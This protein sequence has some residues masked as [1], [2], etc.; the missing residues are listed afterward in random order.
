VRFLLKAVLPK[1]VQSSLRWRRDRARLLWRLARNFAY[2]YRRYASWSADRSI[3][4]RT[5]LAALITMDYH[6][7]EKAL[8]LRDPH[9]AFGGWF[10]PRLLD[11]LQLYQARYGTDRTAQVATGALGAYQRFNSEHGV[12]TASIARLA[13]SVGPSNGSSTDAGAEGG[14][15]SVLSDELRGAS[16]IALER[17]SVRATAFEISLPKTS[18]WRR[19]RQP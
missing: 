3:K 19:S 9:P 13:V 12:A 16:V 5:N 7:I 4:S 8:A 10:L 2:D 1:R 15:R 18:G 14:T 6:R 17:S 11:N